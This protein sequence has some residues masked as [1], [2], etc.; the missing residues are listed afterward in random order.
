[1]LDHIDIGYTWPQ[2]GM[3]TE[4]VTIGWV[5][6]FDQPKLNGGIVDENNIETI[7]S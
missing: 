4:L 5:L 2:F 1:M 7:S 3:V 6:F